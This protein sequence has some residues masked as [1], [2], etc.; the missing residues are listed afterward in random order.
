LE[1]TQRLEKLLK[2]DATVASI[3]V[4]RDAASIA[5]NYRSDGIPVSYWLNLL[6]LADKATSIQTS[7]PSEVQVAEANVLANLT[8]EKT[9][10]PF[11][12]SVSPVNCTVDLTPNECTEVKNRKLH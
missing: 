7:Y 5:I 6:Q 12:E 8:A 2:T 1:Y 4:N 3:R 10:P 11:F 9:Q